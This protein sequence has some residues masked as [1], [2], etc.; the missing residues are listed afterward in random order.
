VI[1][2]GERALIELRAVAKPPRWGLEYAFFVNV[3]EPVKETL[4]AGVAFNG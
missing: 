3:A 1:G 2:Q 4:E